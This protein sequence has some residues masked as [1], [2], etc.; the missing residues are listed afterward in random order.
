MVNKVVS[1]GTSVGQEPWAGGA[2]GW[3]PNTFRGLKLRG[4]AMEVPV[5]AS[6]VWAEQPGPRTPSLRWGHLFLCVSETLLCYS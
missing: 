6:R 3:L 4:E 1:T 2:S 5:A